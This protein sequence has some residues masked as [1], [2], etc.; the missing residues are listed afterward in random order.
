M[1]SQLLYVDDRTWD[2]LERMRTAMRSA[3]AGPDRTAMRR[4]QYDESRRGVLTSTPGDPVTPVYGAEE[5]RVL[6]DLTAPSAAKRI[7]RLL[8]GRAARERN[9]NWRIRQSTLIGSLKAVAQLA[10][11]SKGPA[12]TTIGAAARTPQPAGFNQA[13]G[14][15]WTAVNYDE[16]LAVLEKDAQL[17]P[18]TAADLALHWHNVHAPENRQRLLDRVDVMAPSGYAFAEA[19]GRHTGL[20]TED[21]L[22]QLNDLPMRTAP[23]AAAELLMNGS[24]RLVQ[25][26]GDDVERYAGLEHQVAE[27]IRADFDQLRDAVDRGPQYATTEAQLT[28]S[29]ETGRRTAERA[30]ELIGELERGLDQPAPEPDVAVGIQHNPLTGMANA[31]GAPNAAADAYPKAYGQA[32]TGKSKSLGMG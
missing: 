10:E 1:V 22:H 25:L 9:D 13:L 32:V 5:Y 16:V 24:E 7:G 21:A 17:P 20:S 12:G 27:L 29:V 23:N 3:G 30:I 14:G 31:S 26:R 4:P 18:G 11:A 6:K 15:A 8:P 19:V 2:L 28:R